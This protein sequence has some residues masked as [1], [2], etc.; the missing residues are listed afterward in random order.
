M[1]LWRVVLPHRAGD[2]LSGEGA[3]RFGGRWNRPGQPAVYLSTTPSLAV[4]E[5]LVHV[6]PSDGP[7]EIMVIGYTLPDDEPVTRLGDADLPAGWRRHPVPESVRELGAAWLASGRTLALVVP[8]AVL[9]LT[10]ERN[11]VLNPRH[12]AL[13]RLTE[14]RRERVALNPRMSSAHPAAPP[15]PGPIR[16]EDSRP[17]SR[18]STRLVRVDA[19]G[20]RGSRQSL[21]RELAAGP[22]CRRACSGARR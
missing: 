15:A 3:R 20:C 6:D 12:R 13:S 10:E 1:R 9:P 14:I 17:G 21:R 4:L 19:K 5:W 11:V 18:R 16:S 22:G 7:T 8:S 2:A